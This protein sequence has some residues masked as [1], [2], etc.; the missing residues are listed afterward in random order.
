MRLSL[1]LGAIF[2]TPL[3]LAQPLK[4][5]VSAASAILMN[6]ETGA[7]LYQKEATSPHYPASITK[8]GTALYALEKGGNL[9]ERVIITDEMIKTVSP[10]LKRT[11]KYPSYV[12]EQGGTHI[13]L[14]LGENVS[15]K[16]LFYGLMLSS[17]N[18]A[19]NAIASHVLCVD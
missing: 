15:L 8:I 10:Q 19:A 6:A 13:G 16:T 7:V 4:V 5:S 3:L 11:G 18:D 2:S 1:L 9:E 14:K 17:G 12:L